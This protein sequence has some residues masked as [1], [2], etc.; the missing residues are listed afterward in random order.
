MKTTFL[1]VTYC[2]SPCRE[3]I[4]VADSIGDSCTTE[5]EFWAEVDALGGDDE[6]IKESIL[7]YFSVTEHDVV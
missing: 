1:E 3:S 6:A 2:G 4:S 7:E 5:D